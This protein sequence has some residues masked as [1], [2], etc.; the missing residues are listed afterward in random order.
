MAHSEPG[1]YT[2]T[3]TVGV[4]HE[5]QLPPDCDMA[6]LAALGPVA[7]AAETFAL[8]VADAA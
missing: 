1:Q 7:L 2:L 3:I 4:G 5:I 6:D 8:S